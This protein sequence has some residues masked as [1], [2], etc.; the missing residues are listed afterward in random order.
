MN[1]Q[2]FARQVAATYA[3]ETDSAT[4]TCEDWHG[5]EFV[6]EDNYGWPTLAMP[7]GCVV[8]FVNSDG[9]QILVQV[10]ATDGTCYED[11]APLDAATAISVTR[12]L[13]A[14]AE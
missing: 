7:N 11:F 5:K 8:D 4:Y 12:Q 10:T 13:V 9:D 2:I 3:A 14:D 1:K 6:D